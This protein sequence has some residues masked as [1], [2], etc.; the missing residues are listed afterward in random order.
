ML[1]GPQIPMKSLS[2]SFRGLSTMLHSG[3][4]IQKTFDLAG[5]KTSNA[6]CRTAFKNVADRIRRGDDVTTAMRAQ[7]GAFPLL[8]IDMIAVAE[9]SG[10]MPEILEG[11]ADHYE[12]NLRLWRNFLTA[13]AWPMFQLVAAIFIIAFLIFI[14]GWIKETRGGDTIDFLGLG[15]SGS[16]GALIWLACTFGTMFGLFAG[17]QIAVRSFGGKRFLDPLFLRIPVLGKA[18]RS[19]AIARFS[20]AFYLTQQTGMPI[21]ESLDSSLRATANG[22]FLNASPLL[23][24]MLKSGESL[25]SALRECRLF[26]EDFLHMVEVAETSGTVPEALHRLSPQF[27]EQARRSLTALSVTLAWIVWLIVAG[28]IIY[29]IFRVMLTYLG[30]IQDAIDQT[31]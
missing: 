17:Y 1:F 8:S 12:N 25:T 15:L 21:H 23:C 6:R 16:S 26:P 7:E 4:D 11:L 31:Y 2:Q 18:M 30:L 3:I 5:E 28:F 10:A 24:S 29:F 13:I 27:E 9:Q 20:W 19:F 14:L 22:A